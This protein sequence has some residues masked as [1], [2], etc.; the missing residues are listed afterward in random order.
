MVNIVQTY[1]AHTHVDDFD[2]EIVLFLT[3]LVALA[4][5]YQNHA[6]IKYPTILLTYEE[7]GQMV[8]ET[9]DPKLNV[10]S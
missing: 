4:D 2:D 10:N 9:C 3:H 7:I 6:L 8:P 1:V 5:F